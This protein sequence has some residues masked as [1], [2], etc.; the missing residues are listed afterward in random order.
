MESNKCH[1]SYNKFYEPAGFKWPPTLSG[2]GKRYSNNFC[3]LV[4]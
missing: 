2:G 1:D 3:Q 4:L